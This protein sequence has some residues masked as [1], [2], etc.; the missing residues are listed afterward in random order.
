MKKYIITLIILVIM[1]TSMGFLPSYGNNMSMKSAS[2]T[3]SACYTVTGEIHQ[4]PNED[5]YLAGTI[6]GDLVGTILTVAGPMEIHGIVIFRDIE[7]TWV[8][9]GGVVEGLIGRTLLFEN[10]F[11]GIIND[12]PILKV[13]TTGRLVD[14]AQRGNITLHGW[15]NVS[16]PMTNFL[17]YHGV[18]CP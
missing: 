6:S 10:K 13:N 8:I 9:S 2:S 5:G 7:Q 15:T 4:T 16:P 17:E 12:Y 18:I 3:D 11:R 14:G 1:I